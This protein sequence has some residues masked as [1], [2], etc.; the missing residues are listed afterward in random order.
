MGIKGFKGFREGLICRD[1]QYKENEFF[2]EEVT[3]ELCAKGMHFCEN[4]FQILAYYPFI[5]KTGNHFSEYCEVEALGDVVSGNEKTCTNKL[6]IKNKLTYHQFINSCIDFI[7]SKIIH[8]NHFLQSDYISFS[9]KENSHVESESATVLTSNHQSI[10]ETLSGYSIAEALGH[11]NV[12]ITN[13]ML[14]SAITTNFGSV[15][16]CK[17]AKSV[18]TTFNSFSMAQTLKNCSIAA[19]MNDYSM[20]QSKLGFSIAVAIGEQSIA[21][22]NDFNSVAIATSNNSVAIANSM[23]GIAI[24]MLP[25]DSFAKGIKSSTLIFAP[26]KGSSF[27]MFQVDDEKVKADTLYRLNKQDEL[28]EV[29]GDYEEV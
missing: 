5:T 16:K 13:R 24:A 14:S 29:K 25:C 21:Q 3:P 2:E 22:V 1:K 10:A 20:A 18:A 15:A 4:P 19:A 26:N 11:Q 17:G 28:E 8:T 7:K 27:K 6:F 12:A 23:G 9:S